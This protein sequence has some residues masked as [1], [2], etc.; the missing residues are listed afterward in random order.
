MATNG[1]P[2]L[3]QRAEALRRYYAI[4][5]P[6]IANALQAR[7]EWLKA[8]DEVIDEFDKRGTN[9]GRVKAG[10]VGAHYNS[11]FERYV[12]A[13]ARLQ[14][15]PGAEDFH[16]RWLAWLQ[17]LVRANFCLGEGASRNDFQLL[18]EACATLEEARPLLAAV[19][20]ITATMAPDL[21]PT[22][23]VPM[24]HARI[25]AP[26]RPPA[27]SPQ[28]APVAPAP[29][30]TSAKPAAKSVPLLGGSG[31]K[32]AAKTVDTKKDAKQQKK[33]DAKGGGTR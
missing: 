11:L 24:R 27:G 5:G 8:L 10:L 33:P 19:T 7:V 22:E 15:P 13:F 29:S 30:T 17:R 6:L 25:A 28:P 18:E 23:E 16:Q 4:A 20:R 9:A 21:M 14:T 3:R 26:V 2:D 32:V 31:V 12:Q 1:S